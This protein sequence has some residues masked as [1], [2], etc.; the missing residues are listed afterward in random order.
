M[1]LNFRLHM[2][3]PCPLLFCLFAFLC[4]RGLCKTIHLKNPK[5]NIKMRHCYYHIY[6]CIPP[7]NPVQFYH[8][9]INFENNV[10]PLL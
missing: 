4:W 7:L 1:L 10:I 9:L 3:P 6:L 8:A 5:A 2:S